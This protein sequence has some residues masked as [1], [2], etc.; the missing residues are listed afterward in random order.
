MKGKWS[1]KR[2]NFI[3]AISHNA[4]RNLFLHGQQFS[5]SPQTDMSILKL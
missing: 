3:V 1:S 2:F 4:K 5:Q